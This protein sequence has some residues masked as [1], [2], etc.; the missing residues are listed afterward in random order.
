MKGDERE[1]EEKYRVKCLA[2]AKC[3]CELKLGAILPFHVKGDFAFTFLHFNTVCFGTNSLKNTLAAQS[4]DLR[5]QVGNWR[6]C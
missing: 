6:R 3:K 1:T 2:G 5:V 4:I